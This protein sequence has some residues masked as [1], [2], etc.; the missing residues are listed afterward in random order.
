MTTYTRRTT[1]L[2]ALGAAALGC[3]RRRAD[4]AKAEPTAAEPSSEGV[5][6]AKVGVSN[7]PLAEHSATPA[8]S[9]R[10]GQMVRHDLSFY[11]TPVGRERAVVLVP[12]WIEPGERL[13]VLLALHGRGE[14]VRGLETG[15]YAWVRDYQVERTIARLRAPPLTRTDWQGFVNEER[16]DAVNGALAK[17]PFRGLAIVCPWVPDLIGA[18]RSG[19]DLLRP[20]ARFVNDHLLPRVVAEMPVHRDPA[21]TGI[22]GVSL[23]GRAS[24]LVALECPGRFGA[25]GSLQAAVQRVEAAGLAKRFAAARAGLPSPPKLRLLSSDEDYFRDEILALHQALENE[26]VPHE[27][28]VTRG[29]HDY[30]FNRGPGGIEMLL[31]HDRVLRGER[32]V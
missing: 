3:S 2:A 29:P 25:V 14:S 23:G 26:A 7:T 32:P 1:L 31:W 8:A 16:L 15:A 5:A 17:V 19:A 10:T 21:S 4:L 20:F 18:E 22:D 6:P 30:P 28:F 13:P 12:A 9:A 11:D 24:L 27:H